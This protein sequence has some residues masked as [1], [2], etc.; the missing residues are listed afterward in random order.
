[1][2]ETMAGKKVVMMAV[3]MA[4]TTVLQLVVMMAVLMVLL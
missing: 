4:D 1:M 2:V 3:L